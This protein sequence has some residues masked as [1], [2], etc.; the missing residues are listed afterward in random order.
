[1]LDLG[2]LTPTYIFSLNSIMAKFPTTHWSFITQIRQTSPKS[3]GAMVEAFLLRYLAPMRTFLSY[4]FG[5]VGEADREDLLHDFVTDRIIQRSILDRAQQARGRLRTFVQT[6]LSNFAKSWLSRRDRTRLEHVSDNLDTRSD[7]A[8][9]SEETRYF[10]MAWARHVIT[11]TIVRFKDECHQSGNHTLW[12]VVDFRLIR[13]IMVNGAEPVPF[14]ELA[15][16]LDA[17]IKQLQNLLTTGKNKL[18]RHLID[19]VGDYSASEQEIDD[20]ITDLLRI[21]ERR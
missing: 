17:P 9:E 13:P 1:M 3:R 18:R 4:R 20:E 8:R 15:G 21:V 5:S 7:P 14:K 11:E 2:S 6:C 10:E 12:D 16:R 19:I